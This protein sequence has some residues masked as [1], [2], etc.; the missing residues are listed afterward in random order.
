[1]VYFY[2]QDYMSCKVTEIINMAIYD[3]LVYD[4]K[5]KNFTFCIY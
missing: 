3:I 5:F 2:K 4:L 1:M